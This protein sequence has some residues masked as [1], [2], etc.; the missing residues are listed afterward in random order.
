MNKQEREFLAKVNKQSGIKLNGLE[1]EC[2]IWEGYINNGYG[3]IQASWAKKLGTTYAHRI[4]YHLFKESFLPSKDETKNILHQ[5]DN[6][7][8]VNPEHMRL[9]SQIENIKERVERGRNSNQDGINNSNANFD[10][11][12]LDKMIEL[13][14]LGKTHKAIS[15]HFNCHSKTIQR[16]LNGQ[17]YHMGNIEKLIDSRNAVLR[18]LIDNKIKE[19][20]KKKLTMRKISELV[21]K[22]ASYI[23]S[24][25]NK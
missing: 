4:S 23:C 24:V 3:C 10:Q 18:E 9:G 16:I 13:R 17:R 19:S 8:C 15:E 12:G 25:I 1:T 5:C 11:A 6:T 21:G 14:L 7:K 20:F 22:S 2:W